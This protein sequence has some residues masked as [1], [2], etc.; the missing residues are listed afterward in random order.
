MTK[1]N[2]IFKAKG[3]EILR[4]CEM[5]DV[6]T[7]DIL[8]EMTKYGMTFR[9]VDPSHV[10]ML[11]VSLGKITGK[12]KTTKFGIQVSDLKES[13]EKSEDITIA[14]NKKGD[15]IVIKADKWET[16]VRPLDATTMQSPAFPEIN[17]LSD[18]TVFTTIDDMK[19]GCDRLS[20]LGDLCNLHLGDSLTGIVMGTVSKRTFDFSNKQDKRVHR[21][22]L[23][24]KTK[25]VYSLTYLGALSK[26]LKQKNT[27]TRTL[28]PPVSFTLKKDNYPLCVRGSEGR[29]TWTYF[30]APRI[31][32]GGV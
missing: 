15:L 16:E 10:A 21:T 22:N 32:N 25:S 26:K 8:I 2:I 28:N 11:E 14:W 27:L 1:Q 6:V 3:S 9:A 23:K 17:K 20:K 24:K 5:A 19:L 12:Q 31:E 7:Q 18:K 4:F 29:M 30:L 13:A